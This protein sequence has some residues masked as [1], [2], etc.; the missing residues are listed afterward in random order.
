[1][2]FVLVVA[3]SSKRARSFSSREPCVSDLGAPTDFSVQVANESLAGIEIV[4]YSVT[5][6]VEED[7]PIELISESPSIDAKLFEVMSVQLG[8]GLTTSLKESYSA[9]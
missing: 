2:T 5:G 3:T 8:V 9:R 7:D 4:T 1:M 6:K